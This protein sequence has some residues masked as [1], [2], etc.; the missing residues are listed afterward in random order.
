M[1]GNTGE[2]LLN[3]KEHGLDTAMSESKFLR[4]VFEESKSVAKAM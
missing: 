2:S 4:A 1:H 3:D